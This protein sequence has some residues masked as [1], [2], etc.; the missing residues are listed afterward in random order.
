MKELILR[1]AA[2]VAGLFLLA[3]AISLIVTS[4]LGVTP[5]SAVNYVLSVNT[6]M[7]LGTATFVF[8]IL[9]ILIQFLLITGGV[10]TRKDVVEIL[11]QIP[12]SFIFALFIDINMAFVSNI[13][14]SGYLQCLALLLCGCVVQAFAVV[15][16]LRS[17]VVIM[18]AEGL[19]K[20]ASRRHNKEF[21]RVKVAFDVTLV[22]S[23]VLLS[24]YFCGHV[25]GVREGTVIA[26]V[27]TGIL[28]SIISARIF[29]PLH[30]SRFL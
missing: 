17:N 1:Y 23:A 9:V 16:E 6:S 13:H 19:V 2:F 14:P 20:Y 25:D 5:I 26:A 7:T 30:F 21:G 18:S 12:F 28:V 15:I 27:L 10:G 3:F 8:N 24:L 4:S 11:M 22:I 29:T